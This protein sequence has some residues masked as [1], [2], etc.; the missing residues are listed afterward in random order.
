M[1]KKIVIL[2]SMLLVMMQVF[3][4][5][6]S[7][8]KTEES[9]QDEGIRYIK[10][11]KLTKQEIA[12]QKKHEPKNPGAIPSSEKFQSKSIHLDSKLES[13][14]EDIKKYDSRDYGLITSVK[15]QEGSSWC[16]DYALVSAMETSMIKNKVKVKNVVSTK[17]NTDLSEAALAYFFFNRTCTKD[18]LGLASKD[19]NITLAPG[20]EILDTGCN[21]LVASNFLTTGMGIKQESYYTLDNAFNRKAI[22]KADAYKGNQA[23]VKNYY[24]IATN[25]HQIKAAIMEFG[26]V[27]INVR[28]L[29]KSMNYHTAALYNRDSIA[30]N[31]LVTIVGWD[32]NY[33]RKNFNKWPSDDG[34]WIVKNSWGTDWGDHGYF[35]MSYEDN[36][37]Q[38]ANAIEMQEAD[39]YQNTYFYDGSSATEYCSIGNT[40][41]VA[42]EYTASAKK[43]RCERLEAV[44]FNTQT[45]N[46]DYSIQIYKKL[47][48]KS[49]PESGK[50]AL[51]QEI[52]GTT[53]YAGN[54]MIPVKESVILEP[55]ERYS[56]VISASA[57][58]DEGSNF[59]IEGDGTYSTMKFEAVNDK[60]QSFCKW[61]RADAWLDLAKENDECLRIKAY[62]NKTNHKK[63]VFQSGSTIYSTQYIEPGKAAKAPTVSKK[64][65]QFVKWDKPFDV[66]NE[67]AVINAVFTPNHYN[68]VYNENYGTGTMK[69]HKNVAYDTLFTLKKNLFERKGFTFIGWSTDKKGNGSWYS[70]KQQVKN[71]TDK[72][73]VTVT[74][75][76]G[77]SQNI[78]LDSVKSSKRAEMTVAYAKT[79]K[80]Q[81]GYEITYSTDKN[82]KKS[83][84]KTATI[85]GYKNNKVT[86]K[87]L[88]KGTTYYV[89]VRP[90]RQIGKTTYYGAYT[91][92]KKVTIKR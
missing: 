79:D 72:D 32:D 41:K 17:D 6:V 73:N 10:G 38:E 77:W 24:Q 15:D 47:S 68:V 75:Y 43:N 51:K 21:S 26:S 7:A 42:V 74:L 65:Y 78:T 57:R 13:E 60:N 92:V 8:Q 85:K 76:A 48:N 83:K 58:Y 22:N 63:V 28:I 33:S 53:T 64:G 4:L 19:R 46:I 45:G 2:L 11:R 50:K 49:N 30:T 70:N 31:H 67:D 71:L 80:Y 52:K 25:E 14:I 16:W 84:T 87:K 12:E 66:I 56:I 39:K 55:G 81:T 91:S 20:G 62:T 89:K 29:D 69:I 37:M 34:A 44:S 35:Y 5:N 61:E 3:S 36:A 1:R 9:G 40:G 54:Y 90:Y 23:M 59:G 86:L 27:N 82:F 18:P 88:S